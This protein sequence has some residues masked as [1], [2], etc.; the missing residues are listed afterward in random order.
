M[1]HSIDV[2]H[3]H[4]R[5]G[6]ATAL[7][8]LSFRLDGGKIDGLLGRNGAGKSSLLAVLAAFRQAT[9]GD[10]LAVCPCDPDPHQVFL[11]SPVGASACR[12]AGFPRVE[13]RG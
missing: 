11:I 10:D 13:T 8:D 6:E 5:Y 12:R 1:T 3:L 2:K 9:A 4:L 7:D